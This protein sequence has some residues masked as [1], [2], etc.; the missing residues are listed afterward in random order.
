MSKLTNIKGASNILKQEGEEFSVVKNPEYIF[1][2]YEIYPMAPKAGKKLKAVSAVVMDMDGTTTTT[3]TL[4]IHS[5]EWMIRRMSG[6]MSREEWVGLLPEDYPYIIGNSST[7]HVEYLITKYKKLI[8]EEETLK[9]F[10]SAAH[11]TI[12][13]GNDPLRKKEVLQNLSLLNYQSILSDKLFSSKISAGKEEQIA[14]NLYQ[15]Y[16]RDIPQFKFNLY[17]RLGIDIYYKRYH[18]ILNEIDSGNGDKIKKELLGEGN[19]NVI[20]PM[21]GIEVYLPMLKGLITSGYKKFYDL[22]NN[23]LSANSNKKVISLEEF[24]LLCKYFTKN[25][26]KVAIVTSSI[27]YEA[28]I[29]LNEVFKV[30]NKRLNE[31]ADN[32]AAETLTPIFTNYNNYYDGIVTASDSNEIR[33]KPHRDLYSIALHKL[34]LTVEKFKRV[35]GF[36]DSESGILALRSAGI[37]MAVAVP[38]AQTTQHPF[39]AAAHI[40]KKGIPEVILRHNSFIKTGSVK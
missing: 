38:F 10:L 26:A 33:L 40:C 20:E 39:E 23:H 14:A 5:L 18:E 19:S 24:K 13:K 34:N 4:C 11:W 1:P 16:T 30:V 29:V 8:T 21:P 36:E 12:T 32:K 7:K 31:L 22:L 3:E 2:P 27:F 35:I 17:V 15:K 25:P 37:G 6:K 28:N 9:Y